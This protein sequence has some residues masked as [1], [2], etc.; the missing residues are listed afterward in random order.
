MAG[1]PHR[2]QPDTADLVP[3]AN[4]GV[5]PFG[6]NTFL[7]QEVEPEKRE[8]AVQMITDAGFHWIRQEFPWEDIEIHGKGDFQDRRHEPYRS[9][10]TS[11][12]RS[13]TWPVRMGWRSSPG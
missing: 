3:V 2:P 6:I 9:A 13:W 4:A 10:W 11:T 7:E 12:T 1:Q 8:R 5:N